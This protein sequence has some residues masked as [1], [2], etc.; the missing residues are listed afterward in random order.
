MIYMH[1][2][3]VIGDPNCT[4]FFIIQINSYILKLQNQK[5]DNS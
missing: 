1:N 5:V 2:N 3:Y 4:N